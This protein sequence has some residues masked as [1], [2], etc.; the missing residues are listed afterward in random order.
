[1]ARHMAPS[2]GASDGCANSKVE[3]LGVGL[4][5]GVFIL[6]PKVSNKLT[7]ES[8]NCLPTVELCYSE[9]TQPPS[10]T[11]GNILYR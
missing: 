4:I 2:R 11:A 10:L 8:R 3:A 9:Y 6:I 5:F 7:S 1:M